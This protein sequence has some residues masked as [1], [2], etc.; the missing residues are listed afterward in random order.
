MQASSDSEL[1]SDIDS[2]GDHIN[3]IIDP[4]KQRLNLKE[5]CPRVQ[6]V[7]IHAI[8]EL[9]G[10]LCMVHTFLDAG[11]DSTVFIQRIL[12]NSAK[13]VGDSKLRRILKNEKQ[14]SY[15]KKLGSIVCM[16]VST[17][18]NLR[19]CSL[20]T[21]A[22]VIVPWQGKEDNGQHGSELLRPHSW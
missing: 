8:C 4:A 20:A 15:V 3:L 12:A 7:V 21:S 14:V 17:V 2:E 5:Q 9:E 13:A 18:I 11:T 16:L 6:K 19:N 22:F 1:N 10:H